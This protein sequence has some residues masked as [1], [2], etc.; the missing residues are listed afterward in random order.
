MPDYSRSKIYQL[1]CEDGYYYIGSTIEPLLCRRIANHRCDS[2]KPKYRDN[3][4][5][6]HILKI[7]WDKVKIILIEAVSCTDKDELKMRENEYIIKAENDPLCLNHNRAFLTDDERVARS[8]ERKKACRAKNN[9]VVKCE[10]GI[11]HTVGR[12]DQHRSSV[13]HKVA[14]S[15][16]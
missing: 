1:V 15:L 2:V 12:T 11:E 10:C 6:S 3:K 16:L 13:R 14:I 4:V 8:K 9:V 7:G 5:Y